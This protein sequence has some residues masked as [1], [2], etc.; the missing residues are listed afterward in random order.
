MKSIIFLIGLILG[1]NSAWAG[2]P[3]N[4]QIKLFQFQ[5]KD[6]TVTAGTAVIWT[7]GDDIP[8]SVVPT[9]GSFRSPALDT[10]D[11]FSH[12]FTTPGVYTYFCS[13]HPHMTG[14]VVVLPPAETSQREG[15]PP[16]VPKALL[17][18]YSHQ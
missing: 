13:I 14:K 17:S 8:H 1:G 2:E 4:T 3:V 10:D 16:P 7:N 12:L 6:L 9:D 18:S 11:A 5:P 15:L